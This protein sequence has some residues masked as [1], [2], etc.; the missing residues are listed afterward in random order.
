M[1]ALNP[2]LL[3]CGFNFHGAANA[4]P[5]PSYQLKSS[6]GVFGGVVMVGN[7]LWSPWQPTDD[8]W[9]NVLFCTV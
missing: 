8:K 2:L 6:G 9:I 1:S 4:S 3:Q 7:D 5:V